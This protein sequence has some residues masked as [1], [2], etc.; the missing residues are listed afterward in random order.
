MQNYELI[1]DEGIKRQMEKD[2]RNHHLLMLLRKAFEKIGEK[3]ENAGKL[4]NIGRRIYEIKFKRPPLRIYFKV[5]QISKL[6]VVYGY[7]IKQSQ[8]DQQDYI[9]KLLIKIDLEERFK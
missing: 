4:I 6:A 8:K 2:K 1:F 5:N 7:Q 9:N 3:G